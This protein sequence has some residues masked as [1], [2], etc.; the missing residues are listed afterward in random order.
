MGDASTPIEPRTFAEA[1]SSTEALEHYRGS[2]HRQKTWRRNKRLGFDAR[3]V[4]ISRKQAQKLVQL[5]YLS[6]DSK[7]NKQ[8]E[9]I[10]IEAYLADNL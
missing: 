9:G 4:R 6:L 2:K 1:G 5:G 10:T 8:A 3:T 7:G